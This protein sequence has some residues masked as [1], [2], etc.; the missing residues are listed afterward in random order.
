VQAKQQ[1]PSSLRLSWQVLLLVLL[2]LLHLL[3]L[4]LL[5]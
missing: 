1:P 4:M 5:L 3:V 2:V